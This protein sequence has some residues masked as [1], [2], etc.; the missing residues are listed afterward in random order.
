MQDRETRFHV[1]IDPDGDLGI[2]FFQLPREQANIQLFEYLE[3][4]CNR[5]RLH[6]TINY[7]VPVV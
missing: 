3:I 2:F 6:S 5:Q 1:F 7:A 4:L